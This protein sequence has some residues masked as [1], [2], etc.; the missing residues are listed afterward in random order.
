MFKRLFWVFVGFTLAIAYIVRFKKKVK[1]I[2]PGK[3]SPE[4]IVET[5]QEK[6]LLA[7]DSAVGFFRS[8]LQEASEHEEKIKSEIK[9][10]NS[11]T[12]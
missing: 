10:D 2:L 8:V 11:L 6:V 9:N 4:D 1:Q 5:A 12:L 7:K 3:M